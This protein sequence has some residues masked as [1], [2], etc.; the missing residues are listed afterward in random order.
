M[1][2][3]SVPKKIQ[4]ETL[5]SNF[6]VLYTRGIIIELVMKMRRLYSLTCVLW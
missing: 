6:I 2:V 1:I 4:T 5:K 3:S